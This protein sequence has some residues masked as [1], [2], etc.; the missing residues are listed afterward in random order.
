MK[1]QQGFTLIEL[2]VVLVVLAILTAIAYPSYTNQ[3]IKS[4]RAD[5]IAALNRAAMIME[6][7]RSDNASYVGCEAGVAANSEDGFYAIAA[8]VSAT[9]TA[10]SFEATPQGVQVNDALCTKLTLNSAGTRGYTGD[11]PDADT[12]W[13]Q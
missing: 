5:G 2:M 8:P 6:S 10:Y 9:A 12:C 13:G 7:C 11:A 4:R 3:V 1:R